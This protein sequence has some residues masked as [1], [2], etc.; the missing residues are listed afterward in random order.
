MTRGFFQAPE[1]VHS[2]HDPP[3]RT[4]QRSRAVFDHVCS[5]FGR[6]ISQASPAVCQAETFGRLFDYA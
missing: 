1:C 4:D 2:K 5:V 3:E 6:M